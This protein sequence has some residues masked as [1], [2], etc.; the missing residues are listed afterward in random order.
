MSYLNKRCFYVKVNNDVS[1]IYQIDAGIPQGSV[2]GPV[3]YTI[4]TH[5]MPSRED[6]TVATYADDTAFLCLRPSSSEASR[7]LQLQLD[8]LQQWLTKW[9]II[10]NT[11]KSCHISFTLRREN[12]PP[13]LLNGNVIPSKDTVKYLGLHLDRRLTWKAHISAKRKQ[14]DNKI[15]RMYWLLGPRSKLSLQN[16]VLLLKTI[17]KPIWTYGIGL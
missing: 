10:V 2:L 3:L 15:K 16:K 17:I 4:F 6:I 12:C 11:E 5:D 14:L 13:V 7:I 9:N 1:N 8:N